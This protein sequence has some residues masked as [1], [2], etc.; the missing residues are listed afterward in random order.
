M[1]STSTLIL[2]PTV[3]EQQALCARMGR[4]PDDT[5]V[6]VCG[7]GPVAAAARTALL[8]ARHQPDRILLIG[9]AGALTNSLAPGSA[10]LIDEVAMYGIGAGTGDTFL[11]SGEL[12][13]Q[14]WNGPECEDG[15]LLITDQI[16]LWSDDQAP[17]HRRQLLT[18][19]AASASRKDV[20][21]RL[22]KF[23]N[24]LAED[25]EGFSV[26]AAAR[27]ADVPLGIVRGISNIAGDRDKAHWRILDALHA[28][29]DMAMELLT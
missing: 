7:F 27:M 12:G 3:G 23:P 24:A 17:Q 19:C 10:T 16:S 5:A 6:E 9:I 2:I 21:E 25:M 22:A 13:W 26:A 15:E 20:R 4:L 8:I 14:Q 18:V 29:G 28:A 11:T 1:S